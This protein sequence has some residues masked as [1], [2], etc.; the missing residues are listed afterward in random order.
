M[1]SMTADSCQV[2]ILVFHGPLD[3]A[4]TVVRAVPGFNAVIVGHEQRLIEERKGRTLILSPGEEGNRVG[5]LRV[6]VPAGG[7]A[8]TSVSFTLFSYETDPDDPEVKR[9]ADDYM[10]KLRALIQAAPA[11]K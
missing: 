6:S 1:E 4:E 5:L 10:V 2:K 3:A 8:E 11:G 7:A 9:L